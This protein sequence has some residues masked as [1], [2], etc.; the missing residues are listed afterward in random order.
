MRSE[1]PRAKG[2][3]DRFISFLDEAFLENTGDCRSIRSGG[4]SGTHARRN[5][6]RTHSFAVPRPDAY[7]SNDKE[8]IDGP[9]VEIKQYQ[10]MQ[11]IRTEIWG[12]IADV[13]RGTARGDAD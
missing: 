3:C 6:N 9:R 12:R 4:E 10:N 1:E 2:S 8:E 13:R 5:R 11:I 7:R